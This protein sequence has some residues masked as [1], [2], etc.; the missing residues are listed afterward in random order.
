[1]KIAHIRSSRT[2]GKRDERSKGDCVGMC[3][4]VDLESVRQEDVIKCK[5]ANY[6]QQIE[7]FRGEMRGNQS[8]ELLKNPI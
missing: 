4:R 8:E 6:R 1:M 7:E 2:R 3:F 5:S